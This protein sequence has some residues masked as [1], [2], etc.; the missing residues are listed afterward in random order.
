MAIAIKPKRSE[1]ALSVPSAGDLEIGEIAVNITD[2]KIYSK[3]SG[4]SVVVIGSSGITAL[5]DDTT[6]QLGGNLDLN[7]SNITGTSGGF[8]TGN[9]AN[10]TGTLAEFSF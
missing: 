2:Q 4:G 9:A 1:T 10:L 7:S 8:T 3:S 6:P 5:V